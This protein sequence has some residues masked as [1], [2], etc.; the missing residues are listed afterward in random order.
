MLTQQE[1]NTVKTIHRIT[2]VNYVARDRNGT[3]KGFYE[4][5]ERGK[6]TWKGKS[7]QLSSKLLP[8]LMWESEYLDVHKEFIIPKRIPNLLGGN[9]DMQLMCKNLREIFWFDDEKQKVI[10]CGTIEVH[11]DRETRIPDHIIITAPWGAKLKVSSNGIS[12]RCSD[13]AVLMD[14]MIA[15]PM[16]RLRKYW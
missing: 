1:F 2:E 7:V 14:W 11:Y 10:N 5:P 12:W 3:L 9:G 13:G 15:T 6:E 4:A 8:S 16:E